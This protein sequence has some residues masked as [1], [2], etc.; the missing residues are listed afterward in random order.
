M[1][2]RPGAPWES[3]AQVRSGSR[4]S[5]AGAPAQGAHFYGALR[6]RA[7]PSG[8]PAEM[9]AWGGPRERRDPK[10]GRGW[11]AGSCGNCSELGGPGAQ[12]WSTRLHSDGELTVWERRTAPGEEEQ[13]QE[14]QAAKGPLPAHRGLCT[15]QA[16]PA[17]PQLC[18][19]CG[20]SLWNWHPDGPY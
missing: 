19:S 2:R 1:C 18:L 3:G 12:G 15:S 10:V 14:A 7:G 5:E 13:E 20:F 4:G 17:H 6:S 11:G 8:L 9:G 16:Q